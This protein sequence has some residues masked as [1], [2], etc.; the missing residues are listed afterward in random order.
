MRGSACGSRLG[1]LI[2]EK[3]ARESG[4][5]R[6]QAKI[7]KLQGQGEIALPFSC[8]ITTINPSLFISLLPSQSPPSS[9]SAPLRQHRN[10]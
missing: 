3:A 7:P 6:P 9:R 4:V 5:Q 10:L 1:L 2:F 8:S